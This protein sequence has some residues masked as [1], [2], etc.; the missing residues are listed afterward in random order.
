LDIKNISLWI[1]GAIRKYGSGS[2]PCSKL[3]FGDVKYEYFDISPS[4]YSTF[5]KLHALSSKNAGKYIN[6]NRRP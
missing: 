1:Q 3:G 4:F 2:R 6:L 5:G